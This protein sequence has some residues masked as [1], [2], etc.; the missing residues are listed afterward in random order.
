MKTGRGIV[1]LLLAAYLSF[2][3]R[4]P[5]A[6][7]NVIAQIQQTLEDYLAQ[8][9][10]AETISAVSLHIELGDPGPIIEA[11]AGTDGLRDDQPIDG[12][13]LFQIGS[14][15]KN[16]EA[17]VVLKLEAEGRLNIDQTVGYWLPEYPAW[18]RAKI[19]ELLNMTA[20]IPTYSGTVAIGRI[21]ASDLDYQF[22]NR[23][24]IRAAYPRPG[25]ELPIPTGWFYSNTNNILAA[26][27]I[28]RASDESLK[29]HFEKLFRDVGLHNTFYS[30]GPY[31]HAVLDR[32]PV[33]IFMNPECLNY[34]PAPCTRTVLTP[35][36]GKDMR[37][38]NMSWA[39]GAGAIIASPRDLA[40]YV[41]ALFAGRIIPKLQL[42]EMETVVD[43]GTGKPVKEATKDHPAFGLDLGQAFNEALGGL[44]W[45]YE[46]ETLGYRCIFVY[47]PQYDL[48]MTVA[49]NS[50]PPAGE[51]ELGAFVLGNVWKILTDAGVIPAQP[52]VGAPV[53]P[54]VNLD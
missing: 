50:Q 33:G 35:L 7:S 24:L 30:D 21:L 8:R 25:N 4:V 45:F 39:G 16:F 51:D 53:F 20:S 3:G 40:K 19:R 23:Q 15:T 26:L 14:N 44:Y 29:E 17:A 11:Y 41:R 9:G 13:T 34:E 54:P 32:V 2:P 6:D 22:T 37:L 10:K 48:V 5:A 47:W 18:S 27:I 52:P 46:G 36:L 49:T 38:Q 31:P 43:Q 28:E 1:V 12:D 42:H